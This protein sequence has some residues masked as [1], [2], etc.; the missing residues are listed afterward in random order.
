M[1]KIIILY[2]GDSIESEIS[3]QSAHGI[4][5]NIADEARSNGLR[6]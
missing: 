4:I 5:K 1:R 2:G 6:F 3:L